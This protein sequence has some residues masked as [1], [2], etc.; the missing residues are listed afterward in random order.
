MA[1]SRGRCGVLLPNTECVLVDPDTDLPVLPLRAGE[2]CVRGP[3]VRAAAAVAASLA[4]ALRP[5]LT[6]SSCGAQITARYLHL[7]AERMGQLLD[8]ST[9]FL[10]TADCGAVSHPAQCLWLLGP[11]SSRVRT[12]EGT[13]RGALL[14]LRRARCC[15]SARALH[16]P[17]A[18][19]VCARARQVYAWALQEA[20]QAVRQVADCAVQPLPSRDGVGAPPCLRSR[21]GSPTRAP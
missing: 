14:P 5:P 10:R 4:A 20:A 8:A 7:S 18:R 3:Q 11:V 19:P 16:G 2:V 6:P 9:G 15:P 21:S 17:H 1:A 12:P 13:V